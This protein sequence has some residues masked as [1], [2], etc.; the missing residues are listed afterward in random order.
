MKVNKLL[1][2]MALMTPVDYW[3]EKILYSLAHS[4]SEY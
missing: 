1:A 3:C 4:Y 2:G